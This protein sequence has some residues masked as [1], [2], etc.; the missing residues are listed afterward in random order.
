M[1]RRQINHSPD[2]KKL[3]NEDY[4]VEIV[5]NFLLMHSV[6]YLNAKKELTLGT[7]VSNVSTPKP[8]THVAYFIGD[9]PC[10]VD[11]SVMS[12]L[13]NNSN[14]HDL[15]TGIVIDHLFS[16][17][18]NPTYQ[19]YYDKMV[20]Y[21]KILSAPAQ[22]YFH[23]ATARTGKVLE[24]VEIESVLHY[25]D[26]NSSKAEIDAINQKISGLRI[27]I[28]GLGGT[29]SYIL[30]FV[31]KTLVGEINLFDGDKFLQ[32]N[33]FRSPSAVTKEQLDKASYKVEHYHWI[34]SKMHKH[35]IP[36]KLFINET[37]LGLL[38]NLD[39]VF[40]SIDKSEIKKAI[41][42]KLEEFD[43]PFIDTGIGVKRVDNSL[44]GMVRTTTSTKER[45]EHIWNGRIAFAD[46][47]N[48]DYSTNIQIVELNALNAV[49]AVMKWKKHFGFYNDLENEFDSCY[50]LNVNNITNND[51]AS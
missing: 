45:R 15:G 22:H 14:K 13:I 3:R 20:Q 29:G 39:F 2:I 25:S 4:E 36:H 30:D 19:N 40:V 48:A 7:L 6:P 43:I 5:G 42:K 1:L 49:F 9:T 18:P 23:K 17:K 35:I 38:K 47:D 33:A 37:N 24:D 16:H 44:I 31:A 46:E 27:G 10:N 11:G 32:H 50:N 12:Q 51:N 28:I 8:N 41:F 34:Y 21:V 26:T